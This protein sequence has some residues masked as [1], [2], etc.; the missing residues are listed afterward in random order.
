AADTQERSVCRS[1]YT[2]ES[3]LL[4]RRKDL[5]CPIRAEEKLRNADIG[6]IIGLMANQIDKYV[7]QLSGFRRRPDDVREKNAAMIIVNRCTA[8]VPFIWGLDD[9]TTKRFQTDVFYGNIFTNLCG[10]L[11]SN[12]A[13]DGSNNPGRKLVAI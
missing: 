7:E 6:E 3:V 12:M 8:L 1:R 11:Q 4:D 2:D 9:W 5:V 13:P 10:T